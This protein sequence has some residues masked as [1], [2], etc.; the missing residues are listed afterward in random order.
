[1][2]D[3]KAR[4]DRRRQRSEEWPIRAYQL[5]S[6][7]RVDPLDRSTVDERIA[8]M[9]PLARTAWAVAG[10]R[11]PDYARHQA[12]GTM[13]RAAGRTKDLADVEQLASLEDDGL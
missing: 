6:E 1:M 9:W 12:P 10:K 7:P 2:D 8:A 5:G 4:A 13:I 3:E 11:I